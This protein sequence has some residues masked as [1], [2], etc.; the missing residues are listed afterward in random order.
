MLGDD[1][2]GCLT[3]GSRPRV[4]FCTHCYELVEEWVNPSWWHGRLCLKCEP[5][6]EREAK[7][8]D[9]TKQL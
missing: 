9:P 1:E 7:E 6:A 8:I 5:I 4:E 2:H 3:Y